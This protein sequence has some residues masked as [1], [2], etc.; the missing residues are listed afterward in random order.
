MNLSLS[1]QTSS[2]FREAKILDKTLNTHH[3]MLNALQV[4]WSVHESQAS[5]RQQLEQTQRSWSQY[6]SPSPR[7]KTPVRKDDSNGKK[8]KAGDPTYVVRSPARNGAVFPGNH[9]R[10]QSKICGICLRSDATAEIQRPKG[11]ISQVTRSGVTMETTVSGLV[12]SQ[13]NRPTQPLAHLAIFGGTRCVSTSSFCFPGLIKT[14]WEDEEEKTGKRLATSVA[15]TTTTSGSF[16]F[17]AHLGSGRAKFVT[18]CL[19]PA[20]L[21]GKLRR[22]RGGSYQRLGYRRLWGPRSAFPGAGARA[23]KAARRGGDGGREDRLPRPRLGARARGGLGIPARPPSCRPAAWPRSAAT[24]PS[25]GS[26][27]SASPRTE[28]CGGCRSTACR[29]VSP[30]SSARTALLPPALTSPIV[31]KSLPSRSARGSQQAPCPPCTGASSA[32]KA[33]EEGDRAGGLPLSVDYTYFA[34]GHYHLLPHFPS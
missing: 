4:P 28:P 11:V 29:A 17:P 12:L 9:G 22:G 7:T 15:V 1:Q 31:Q 16:L 25:P 18:C 14:E 33:E 20:A 30:R 19:L 2:T 8:E 34:S 3:T 23:R 27:C 26:R 13:I 10:R 32:P 21:W 24:P 5:V 6:Y